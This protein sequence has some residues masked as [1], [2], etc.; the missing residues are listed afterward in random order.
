MHTG[1]GLD[2]SSAMVRAESAQLKATL[3][4]LV[5]RLSSVPGLELTVSRRHGRLRRLIGDLPYVNDLHRSSDPIDRLVVSVARHTYSLHAH[6]DSIVCTRELDSI[7][8]GPVKE[9]LTF[10]AWALALFDDISQQ[11][12]ANHES[13]VALRH[14]VERDQ[15]QV[16]ESQKEE[17]NAAL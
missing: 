1:A 11:N 12:F 10:S 17:H 2:S 16:A 7:E 3:S 8:R 13:L 9:R 15:V 6:E 4:A 5:T 14:L